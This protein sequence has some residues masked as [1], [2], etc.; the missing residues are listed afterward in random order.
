MP[1]RAEIFVPKI[2]SGDKRTPCILPG[3]NLI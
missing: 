3:V 2:D 1:R